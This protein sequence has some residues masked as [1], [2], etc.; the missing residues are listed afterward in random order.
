MLNHYIFKPLKSEQKID[1][2]E[3]LNVSPM[4]TQQDALPRLPVPEFFKE[5]EE[6]KPK[7]NNWLER[8]VSKIIQ[9]NL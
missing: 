7:A 6:E 2:Q 4:N 9:L 5:K 3:V 1:I 8:L